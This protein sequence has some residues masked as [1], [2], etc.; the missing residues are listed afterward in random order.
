MKIICLL[1]VLMSF[2][3]F[4]QTESE[5]VDPRD[6]KSYSSIKIRNQLWFAENLA[7]RLDSGCYSFKNH[8]RNSR[9]NGFLYNWEAAQI[10]CPEGWRI[11]NQKDFE[12]LIESIKRQDLSTYKSFKKNDLGFNIKYSGYYWDNIG[13]IKGRFLFKKMSYWTSELD[14]YETKN[15]TIKNVKKIFTINGFYKSVEVVRTSESKNAY[16]VRCICET[17]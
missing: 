2:Q 7:F 11:P 14:H 16:A 6:G 12:I 10:A 1:F 3:V 17:E 4:G 8:E 13:F 9:K 15:G 5:I